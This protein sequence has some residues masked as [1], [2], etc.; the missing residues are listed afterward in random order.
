[1]ANALKARLG[2]ISKSNEIYMKKYFN[3]CLFFLFF[4]GICFGANAANIPTCDDKKVLRWVEN[5]FFEKLWIVPRDK[6]NFQMEF[7]TETFSQ[8]NERGCEVILR[9]KLSPSGLKEM[10]G[11]LETWNKETGN[12]R[13]PSWLLNFSSEA[14]NKIN[15][16]LKYDLIKKDWFGQYSSPV[17]NT[18][19]PLGNYRA[20][21]KGELVVAIQREKDRIAREEE[22][23]SEKFSREQERLANLQERAAATEQKRIDK[24]EKEEKSKEFTEV[25]EKFS[26]CVRRYLESKLSQ[27]F[28]ETGVVEFQIEFID[29]IYKSA[30]ITNTPKKMFGQ[31]LMRALPNLNCSKVEKVTGTVGMK[32]SFVLK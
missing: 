32:F 18:N 25:T 14:V 2:R 29:G 1:V 24:I 10:N 17:P 11:Y 21:L 27:I 19:S 12:S 9:S 3:I 7:L 15:F 31:A 20:V 23:N 13:P 8:Q 28:N 30:Q 4:L 22:R 6:V 5:I 26:E 16:S